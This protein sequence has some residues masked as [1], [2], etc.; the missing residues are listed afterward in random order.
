MPSAWLS[1]QIRCGETAADTLKGQKPN[2]SLSCIRYDAAGPQP[3]DPETYRRLL[4]MKSVL[5][6]SFNSSLLSQAAWKRY[7]NYSIEFN[8]SEARKLNVKRAVL[9]RSPYAA[10]LSGKQV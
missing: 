8:G 4:L 1:N 2:E 9:L 6:P 10:E 7:H 3:V 5:L